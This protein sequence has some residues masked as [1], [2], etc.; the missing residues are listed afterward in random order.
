MP[1][2]GRTMEA[3]GFILFDRSDPEAGRAA[4]AQAADDIRN[5]YSLAIAPEGTRSYTGKLEPFKKGAFHVAMQTQVPIVPIVIKNAAAFWP[6]G[7]NFVRP[8][9][10]DVE[11]LPPV[12]TDDWTL[13]NLGERVDKL[14]GQFLRALGQEE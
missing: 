2:I 12:S 7:E 4:C 13:E 1:L 11:V 8:G 10:V 6:R 5:G 9:T 3:A 14:R